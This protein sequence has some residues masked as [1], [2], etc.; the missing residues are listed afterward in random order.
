MTQIQNTTIDG[1]DNWQTFGGKN[2]SDSY[3]VPGLSR[4][5][6]DRVSNLFDASRRLLRWRGVRMLA[7]R[8]S[9]EA[10]HDTDTEHEKG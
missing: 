2:L 7:E 8:I 6:V 1:V 10:R 5:A 3:G 9:R 4:L